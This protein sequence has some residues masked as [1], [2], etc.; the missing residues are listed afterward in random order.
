[1]IGNESEQGNHADF[2][3]SYVNSGWLLLCKM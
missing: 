1:M 2:D 3:N